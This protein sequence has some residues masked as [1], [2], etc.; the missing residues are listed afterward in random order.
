MARKS[1]TRGPSSQ[2]DPEGAL[3]QSAQKIWLAGLGA[4]ERAKSEGPK[5]F[6]VLVEQGRGFS[7][8]AREAADHAL[9]T[10]RDGA[11]SAPG[12]FDKLEQ[13]FEER[14]SRTLGR[15]GVLTRGEVN[16]LSRQVGELSE[17]VRSMLAQSRG[18]KAAP[19]RAASGKRAA[20]AR[21]TKRKAA[22]RG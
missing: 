19:K 17:Q 9:K 13:V 6:N 20:G 3:A 8:R 12:R 11:G 7:D 10:L 5:M 15:L 14:V 22:H 1:S 2:R 18:R 21:T 16:D 4:F